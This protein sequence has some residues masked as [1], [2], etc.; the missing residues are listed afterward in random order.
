MGESEKVFVNLAYQSRVGPI[1]WL[2]PYTDDVLP[3]L[4]AQGVKNLVVV[5]I[6]FVSEHIETLEE[7]DMEYR[8]LAEENGIIN[9]RRCQALNTDPSFIRDMADM[10]MEALSEPAQSVTEACISN[11][12]G[13]IEDME[14]NER[15][16]IKTD[17][18]LKEEAVSAEKINGRIAMMG[19]AGTMLMEMLNGNS[20]T[21]MFGM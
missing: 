19:V 14:I 7:I 4:G 15:M 9:W 13:Q 16:G 20:V 11:N 17:D 21:R 3:E 18:S 8:E 10:V 6:S 5:P 2:R 12:C 1:E